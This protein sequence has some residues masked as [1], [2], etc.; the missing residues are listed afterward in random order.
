MRDA[1]LHQLTN[2]LVKLQEKGN[3]INSLIFRNLETH[4]PGA[5]TSPSPPECC[6][7]QGQEGNGG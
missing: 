7:E 5:P 2:V 3:L 4:F 1:G 6:R